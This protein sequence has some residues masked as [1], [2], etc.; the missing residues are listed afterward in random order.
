FGKT[1]TINVNPLSGQNIY[2]V[3]VTDTNKCSSSDSI[4]IDGYTL[5]V[6]AG[7]D[8]LSCTPLSNYP[9]VGLTNTNPITAEFEWLNISKTQ[10]INVNILATNTF[11]LSVK[12]SLGCL[13]SDDITITIASPPI[14]NI[15]PFSVCEKDSFTLSAT[16]TGKSPYMY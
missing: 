14:V 12:D 11:T 7:K 3:T 15:S 8:T 10:N 4:L 2:I 9:L 13:A 6:N 5:L 1:K 16:V